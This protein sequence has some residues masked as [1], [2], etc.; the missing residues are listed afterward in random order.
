MTE[1]DDD[2]AALQ[3]RYATLLDWGAKTGFA[4]AV[5]AFAAYVSG[6]L[7]AHVALEQLPVLWTQSLEAYLAE[8]GAPTGWGWLA[9]LGH[10]EYAGIAGIAILSGCSIP[11]LLAVMPLFAKR[12]EK[13]MATVCALVVAVLLLAASGILTAGH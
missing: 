4:V 8:T 9:Q 5:V 12:G 6:V 11:C 13:V 2:G 1:R 7:P 10:G 3:R